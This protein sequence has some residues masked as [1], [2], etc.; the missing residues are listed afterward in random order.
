MHIGAIVAPTAN[1]WRWRWWGKGAHML[2]DA[3]GGRSSGGR[4]RAGYVLLR[5]V[6]TCG[7]K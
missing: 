4:V 2:A 1:C 7:Y 6:M 3:C 5:G